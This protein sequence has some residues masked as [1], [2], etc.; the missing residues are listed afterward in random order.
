MDL[1][2]LDQLLKEH[3]SS[4]Q[5]LDI[6]FGNGRNLI[7]FIQ[8]NYETF[9]IDTDQGSVSLMQLIAR[10]LGHKHEE[11]FQLGSATNL[12]FEKDSFDA[13]L[14]C[15]VFHFLDSDEKRQAWEEIHNVLKPKALLYLTVNSTINFEDRLTTN[16]DGESIFP[17]GTSGHFL[18]Q[19]MLT[20]FESDQRFTKIEPIRN[21][22]YDDSHAETI[23]VFRK[24]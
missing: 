12:S 2:L 6:G 22:Q 19:K 20:L 21:I 5:I 7:H 24:N 14:C 8:A 9:G 23:L 16:S 15:R 18:D 10:N 11:H 4:G 13:V 3:I 17:D 1:Y